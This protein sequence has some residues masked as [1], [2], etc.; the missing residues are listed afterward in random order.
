MSSWGACGS[1]LA[2]NFFLVLSQN[3]TDLGENVKQSK[4]YLAYIFF[5]IRYS[6][7]AQILLHIFLKYP[8]SR[9]TFVVIID[10]FNFEKTLS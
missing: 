6:L 4:C 3:Y 5:S 10:C 8:L 1:L 2:E 7:T 9:P